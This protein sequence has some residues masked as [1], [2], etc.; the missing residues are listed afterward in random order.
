MV[1]IARS[2]V[3]DKKTLG[4]EGESWVLK[5]EH[6]TCRDGDVIGCAYD[7]VASPSLPST[8]HPSSPS[9]HSEP[10]PPLILPV[11]R[12]LRIRLRSRRLRA[13]RPSSARARSTWS[14]CPPARGPCRP[15]TARVPPP[16]GSQGDMPTA[17]RFFHNGGRRERGRGG[18]GAANAGVGGGVGGGGRGDGGVGGAR[19]AREEGARLPAPLHGE[20]ALLSSSRTGASTA[21]GMRRALS[22]LGGSPSCPPLGASSP[23]PFLERVPLSSR[24]R[25]GREPPARGG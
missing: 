23:R 9:L 13:N 24:M 2:H 16:R 18:A 20:G 6:I 12:T 17:L 25:G 1:G 8:I 19:Q 4:A 11:F 22:P 5:S 14:A 10:S 3:H 7:Q 21:V 15:L